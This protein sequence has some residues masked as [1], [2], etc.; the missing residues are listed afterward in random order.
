[1]RDPSFENNRSPSEGQPQ[2]MKRVDRER[3]TRFHRC[4][5]TA[6]LLDL[7]R[8][9]HHDFAL[10]IAE[11]QNPFGIPLVCFGAQRG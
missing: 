1:M 4:S 6:D 9:E 3:E 5:A 2:L 11:N 8:L 7:Q 10:E